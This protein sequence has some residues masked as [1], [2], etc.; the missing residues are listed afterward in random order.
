M[1]SSLRS[2]SVSEPVSGTA[3]RAHNYLD[4][5]P[6]CVRGSRSSPAHVA[7]ADL[8]CMYS[9]HMSRGTDG[10]ALHTHRAPR[11]PEFS[12]RSIL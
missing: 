5:A 3:T 10:V 7:P 2:G 11:C 8:G 4:L 1:E 12:L 6:A 9:R